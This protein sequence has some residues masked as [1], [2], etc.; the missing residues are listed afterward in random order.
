MSSVIIKNEERL[1]VDKSM[2]IIIRSKKADIEYDLNDGDYNIMIFNDTDD[3]LL[4][5]DHGQITNARVRI[6]YLQLDE[7]DLS[8][9]SSIMVN[10]NSS[11]II[12][13]T[14]L[15]VKKKNVV[16]DLYNERPDSTIDITNNTVCLDKASFK[17]DCIGTI[18][19]GSKRSR[20]HQANRCL[21][22]GVPEKSEILPVL[23]IDEND[24]EAS[25]SLSSG[26]IDEEILFYMN[27]RG[28]NAK[29]ALNLI[30]RSYLM[31]SDDYYNDF[32]DGNN[33]RELAVK[34]VDRLC[35]M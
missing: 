19:K 3:D 8:Q 14:Y 33:I 16:Y 2:T 11:L 1:V 10:S 13:A 15:G 4:L 27:S 23:N 31:P 5:N 35:S 21:T 17:L 22:F 28:L 29:D 32:I 12:T 30:L 25:H 20:C 24:V 26:T 34:K 9:K 7:H 6:A 18:K